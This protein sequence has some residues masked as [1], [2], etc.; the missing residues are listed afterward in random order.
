MPPPP[1][2]PSG[3]RLSED[4]ARLVEVAGEGHV[5]LNNLLRTVRG[6]G[7]PALLAMLALPFV[8]PIPLPGLS[9]PLGLAIG[10]FGLRLAM[11]RRP[12]IPRWLLRRKIP[13]A[14]VRVLVQR[15]VPLIRRAE[16][17]LHPRLLALPRWPLFRSITGLAVASCGFALALPLPIPFSNTIP[18]AGALLLAAGIME[19]DGLF[20][21]LGWA[22]SLAAWAYLGVLAWMGELG[23]HHFTG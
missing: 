18:A 10:L 4:L 15:G 21:L 20:I 8:L 7:F 13:P 14:A 16:R 6:R 12:L 17:G 1:P 11:L 3:A 2:S 23:L 5:T 22:A 19:D 9:T